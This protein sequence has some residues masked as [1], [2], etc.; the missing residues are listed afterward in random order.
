MFGICRIWLL[1][2]WHLGAIGALDCP[3][4]F[5]AVLFLTLIPHTFY[6]DVWGHVGFVHWMSHTH[7]HHIAEWQCVLNYVTCVF[8]LSITVNFSG[9]TLTSFIDEYDPTIEDSYRKQV[10]I[11]GETCLLD[12]LDTAGQEEY[13]WARL[14]C[15]CVRAA[16]VCTRMVVGLFWWASSLSLLTLASLVGCGFP[17]DHY[18]L[19]CSTDG[20]VPLGPLLSSYKYLSLLPTSLHLVR[21]TPGYF[22][23]CPFPPQQ[24]V[25]V[26]LPSYMPTTEMCILRV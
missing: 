4:K 20:F 17:F 23:H 1:Y 10:V 16:C 18:H 6:L 12:I 8:L 9:P 13:R 3:L 24:V 25:S 19:G 2:V 22:W 5:L 26:I 7:A 14:D 15:V 21:F 11:D